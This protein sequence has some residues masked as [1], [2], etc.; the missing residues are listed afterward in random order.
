MNDLQTYISRY[1]EYCRCQKRLDA[2]TVKAYR[3]DL[4]QFQAGMGSTSIS[5]ITPETLEDFIASLHQKYKPKT[6]KRKLASI[7]ALF[8]YFEYKEI[9]GQNPF[10]KMQIKFR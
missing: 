9:I 8:R 1:L 3:I 10:H 6:V 5:E 2:K 4:A 7:K